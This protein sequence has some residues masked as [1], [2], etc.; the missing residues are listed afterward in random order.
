MTTASEVFLKEFVLT[1][2]FLGGLF[3]W[4][5]VDPDEMIL[6]SLLAVIYPNNPFM[7]SLLIIVF[8]IIT[9]A[10]GILGTYAMA[11]K[12]GLIVVGVAWISGFIIPMGGTATVVGGLLF[13]GAYIA[14]PFVCGQSSG[15]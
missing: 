9:T 6:R 12:L 4:A 1:F 3:A 7:V 15:D 8:V 11:G 2:G 14:G 13:V 10:I 5:G